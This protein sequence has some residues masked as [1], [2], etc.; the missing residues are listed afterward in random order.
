VKGR[1]IIKH[2]FHG[3]HIGDTSRTNALI[4]FFF[5]F[6]VFITYFLSGYFMCFRGEGAYTSLGAG[7]TPIWVGRS[8]IISVG[9]HSSDKHASNISTSICWSS[10]PVTETLVKLC[11]TIKHGIHEFHTGNIPITKIIDLE[12][13][14]TQE[15]EYPVLGR[16]PCINASVSSASERSFRNVGNSKVI[17]ADK[18]HFFTLWKRWE[19]K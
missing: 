5:L 13:I 6:P 4:V 8:G 18:F 3:F 7:L 17:P 12:W 16:A 2:V 11:C 15:L 10:T 14:G 1:C 9:T 19:L